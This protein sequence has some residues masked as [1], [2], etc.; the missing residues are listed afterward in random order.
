[1]I[2]IPPIEV[3]P[4]IVSLPDEP[5][6]ETKQSVAKYIVFFPERIVSKHVLLDKQLFLD[7]NLRSSGTP[8]RVFLSECALNFQTLFS[9]FM[10]NNFLGNFSNFWDGKR[11]MKKMASMIKM[12]VIGTL[13]ILMQQS[14]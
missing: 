3:L 8:K 14:R 2:L 4:A 10:Y 7:S 5:H 13:L 9:E 6:G 1:M 12:F 11:E